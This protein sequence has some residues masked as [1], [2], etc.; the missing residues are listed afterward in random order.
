MSMRPGDPTR[1]RRLWPPGIQ[2]RD[3]LGE[4]HLIDPDPAVTE[5]VRL[6]LADSDPAADLLDRL[7]GNIGGLLE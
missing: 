1:P 2:R 3:A 7:F 4:L 6:E 5:M